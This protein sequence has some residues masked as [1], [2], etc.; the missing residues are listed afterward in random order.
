MDR[1]QSHGLGNA[2][3]MH[4]RL[5]TTASSAPEE[6]ALEV[7][8]TDASLPASTAAARRALSPVLSVTDV[9]SHQQRPLSARQLVRHAW[10]S[11]RR[12]IRMLPDAL[13]LA[14]MPVQVKPEEFEALPDVERTRDDMR[15]H[16]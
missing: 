2:M 7:R 4:P 11:L 5:V 13:N 12:E 15:V 14:P 1:S 3:S 16:D 10:L 8:P 6:S 9:W